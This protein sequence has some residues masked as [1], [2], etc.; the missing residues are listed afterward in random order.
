MLMVGWPRNVISEIAYHLTGHHTHPSPPIDGTEL[1]GN[2][3]HAPRAQPFTNRALRG[4]R[5]RPLLQTCS[6]LFPCRPSYLR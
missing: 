5:Q 4:L 3:P 6:T 1:T 2:P